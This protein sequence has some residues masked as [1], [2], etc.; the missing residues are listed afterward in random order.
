MPLSEVAAY[1]KD[2]RT[3]KTAL[4]QHRHFAFIAD[5]LANS[6]ERP[7]DIR[8][9]ASRFAYEFKRSNHRFD[10]ARFFKAVGVDDPHA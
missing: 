4:M 10:R 2:K 7:E 3:A 9:W 1:S 5:I 6:G 8:R